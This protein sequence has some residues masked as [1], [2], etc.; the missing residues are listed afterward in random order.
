MLVHLLGLKINST[1]FFNYVPSWG[2]TLRE[3]FVKT[4][5]KW[6]WR[7]LLKVMKIQH[8]S[9][10]YISF[11]FK[12]F[13]EKKISECELTIP[14]RRWEI[15]GRYRKEK[16]FLHCNTNYLKCSVIY[17]KKKISNKVISYESINLI[18][19]KQLNPVEFLLVSFGYKNQIKKVVHSAAGWFYSPSFLTLST[20]FLS[21]TYCR[22]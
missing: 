1:L 2:R 5:E 13:V 11:G 22:F 4:K 7:R 6:T 12:I 20:N 9:N 17:N 8:F 15:H 16:F 10:I 18:I 3:F 14:T 19:F 21:I